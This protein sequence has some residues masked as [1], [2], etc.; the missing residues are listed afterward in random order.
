MFVGAK[1]KSIFPASIF[2]KSN[3]SLIIPESLCTFRIAIVKNLSE[4]GVISPHLPLIRMSKEFFIEVNG[5]LSSCET[6][7]INSDFRRS[8]R[9]SLV[10]VSINS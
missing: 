5:V 6:I 4:A 7:E 10:F 8:K 1:L 9:S 3:R 2:D